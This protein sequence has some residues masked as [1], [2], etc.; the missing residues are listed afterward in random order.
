MGTL[1]TRIA[2]LERSAPKP[3]A[4]EP[5]LS[6]EEVEERNRVVLESLRSFAENAKCFAQL[7][8]E[9]QLAELL[10]RR[11]SPPD[12]AALEAAD[13][14]I[15]LEAQMRVVGARIWAERVRMLRERI[16]SSAAPD[17]PQRRSTSTD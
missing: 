14:G 4:V 13:L 10:V 16:A 9:T 17:S 11:P 15:R 1:E 2:R 7:P 12:P 3:A 6:A 5:E 8:A